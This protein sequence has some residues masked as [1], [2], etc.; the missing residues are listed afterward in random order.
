MLA[1]V[2]IM[3]S[4]NIHSAS[5]GGRADSLLINIQCLPNTLRLWKEGE[6]CKYKVSPDYFCDTYK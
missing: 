5:L 4:M 1:F 2:F 6:L 3:K